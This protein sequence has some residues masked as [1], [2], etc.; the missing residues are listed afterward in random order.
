MA[1]IDLDSSQYSQVTRI[2]GTVNKEKEA[3]VDEGSNIKVSKEVQYI[4]GKRKKLRLAR[5]RV[6]KSK[7]QRKR[8]DRRGEN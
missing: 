4:A 5:S 1:T 6:R 2:C 3:K 7:G 8:S